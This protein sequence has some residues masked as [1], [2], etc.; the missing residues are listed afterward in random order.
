MGQFSQS[1]KLA[2]DT[3]CNKA[4][5]TRQASVAAAAQF[6]AGQAAVVA[7]E[8]AWPIAADQECPLLGQVLEAKRT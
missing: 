2:H 4:G 5:S 7:A 1:G 3:A 8:I 6:P